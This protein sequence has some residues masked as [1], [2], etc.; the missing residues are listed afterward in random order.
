MI[1]I[2][3]SQT[4]G[5][6]G[7]RYSFAWLI[8]VVCAAASIDSW[9]KL[10]TFIIAAGFSYLIL[11]SDL[12]WW[13]H[14]VDVGMKLRKIIVHDIEKYKLL[15]NP[16]VDMIAAFRQAGFDVGPLEQRMIENE[17]RNSEVPLIE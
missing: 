1:K 13:Q 7:R 2:D 11:K 10:F 12:R 8:L 15:Q 3:R 9:T 4:I 17:Q 6:R 16:T 14:D 5:I